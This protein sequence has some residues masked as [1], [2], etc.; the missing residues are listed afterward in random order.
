M[1]QGSQDCEEWNQGGQSNY[2]GDVKVMFRT[3]KIK[4]PFIQPELA[5][6]RNAA[7]HQ[8]HI[9]KILFTSD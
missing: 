3:K 7:R 4:I 1:S 2:T 9:I 5:V 6:W 8:R